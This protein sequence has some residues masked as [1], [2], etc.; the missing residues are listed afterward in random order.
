VPYSTDHSTEL[1][2]QALACLAE[3]DPAAKVAQVDA[4]TDAWHKRRIVLEVEQILTPKLPIPG[5]PQRP[6]LVPPLAVGR[7]S[8]RTMEGRAALIH[9][10]AHIEFNAIN[11]ALDAVWRFA[12]MPPDYYSDWLRVAAE[13][14]L[15]FS[16]LVR[17]LRALGYVYG[18]FDAHNSLWDM[19]E[20]TSDDVL[21]RIALVPRT[22]EAR[23]LD[24]SPAMRAKL[25]SVSWDQAQIVDASHL[26]V[27]ASRTN[28]GEGDLDAHLQRIAEVRG[29]AV[30]TL[31]GFRNMMAGTVLQGMDGP[32]RDAW[33]KNQVFIALGILLASAAALGIDACPM[34]GF[35]RDKYDAILG[36][37]Q[38]RLASAAV[39]TLGY[40]SPADKYAVA[41]KV[42]F[43]RENVF[44][45]A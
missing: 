35:E 12:G 23:G 34:E 36:L 22:L 20:K 2:A 26:V 16:L 31:A 38:K 25:R 41:P 42:R 30:E 19:A 39:A 33:A 10:L 24:A 28:L 21:A 43:P 6:N 9:A 18:D 5:R 15:H 44:L 29:V 14:A 37:A 45:D 17:H 11:L 27:F 32:T 40:R 8:M 4:L 7:R 13:E 1:R 3:P